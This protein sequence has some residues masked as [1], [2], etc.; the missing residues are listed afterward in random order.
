MQPYLEINTNITLKPHSVQIH[1]QFTKRKIEVK[2][3]SLKNLIRDNKYNGFMSDATGRQVKKLI[4]NWLV[5]I[6]I[7]QGGK[8]KYVN[9]ESVYP[10]FVTLTLP[11][12]QVHDDNTL[13]RVLLEPMIQWLTSE[14]L[15]AKGVNVGWGVKC[16]LWRAETQKNGNLHFHIIVDRW[17]D[18]QRLRTKWNQILDR[19]GYIKMF[20][21]KQKHIFRKG[22]VIRQDQMKKQVKTLRDR[23]KKNGKSLSLKAAQKEATEKQKQAWLKGIAE[24]WTNP[25]ST[26]VH[27][28]GNIKSISAYVTKYVCK[29]PKPLNPVLDTQKVIDGYLYDINEAYPEGDSRRLENERKY[30]AIYEE[31]NVRGRI[32]GR[33]D[34]LFNAKPEALKIC[35]ETVFIDFDRDA[36]QG[37]NWKRAEFTNDVEVLEYTKAVS[38]RVPR[39]ERDRLNDRIDSDFIYIIPLLEKQTDYLKILSPELNRKYINHYLNLFDRLYSQAA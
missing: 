16:Y 34:A 25:N 27:K 28:L 20:Q 11:F 14:K 36:P 24:N 6:E 18:M 4:E 23:A 10:T 29:K 22:F 8:I 2:D 37:Q 38:G 7:K 39:E 13:K 31:R 30:V 26:D 33:S 19:L 32:W 35:A 15:D 5:S 1:K 21:A 17:I 12:K 3:E 9:R